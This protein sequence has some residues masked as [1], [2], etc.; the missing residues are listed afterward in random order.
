MSTIA[1]YDWTIECQWIVAE[2][3]QV[4]FADGS[5]RDINLTTY[6]NLYLALRGGGSNF[7]IVTRFDLMTN[8]QGDLWGGAIYWTYDSSTT[9]I[10]A[11]QDF[12]TNAPEDKYAT[13]I[14]AFAFDQAASM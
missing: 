14:L 13:L 4:V 12:N 1:R 8:S 3:L 7:G 9:L 6:S 10:Q 11:L 5:I 2:H